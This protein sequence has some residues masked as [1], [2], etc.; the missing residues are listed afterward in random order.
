MIINGNVGPTA[1]TSSLGTGTTPVIRLGN[2]GDV[3]VSELQPRYYESTYR[4]ATFVGANQAAVTTSAALTTTWTG[5]MLMNPTTSTVNL[6]VT[7]FMVGQFAVGAAAGV[8]L[9]TGTMAT[10]STNLIVGRNGYVGGALPQG[11]LS[12]G[13][14][15]GT[16]VLE[17][18]VGSIGSLATTG[19]GLMPAAYIDFEGSLILPPGAFAASY[20]SIATTSAL[21]FAFQWSEIPI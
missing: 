19:Y 11:L 1:T 18:L 15:I 9:M 6:V 4:R 7:K 8:G 13:A 10:V 17:R 3:I 5:L 2:M 14:T 20:T 16:P 21:I 12:S